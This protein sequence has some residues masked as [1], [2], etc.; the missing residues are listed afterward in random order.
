MIPFL[1]QARFPAPEFDN[2]TLPQLQLETLI[3]DPIAWRVSALLIFLV[4][5]GLCFYRWRSS[6]AMRLLALAG[7]VIFG[8]LFTACPCPVGMFQNLLAAFVHGQPLGYGLLLLFAIPLAAALLFG[9]LFCAGACPL[10]AVQEL[11]LWKPIQIPLHVDRALRLIP[12]A[13]F[14]LVVVAVVAG[15]AFPLCSLDPYLPLFLWS[16]SIPTVAFLVLGLFVSRPFC[17]YVCP[18]GVLLRLFS[19]VSWKTPSVTVQTCI[20]CRL[21]EQG[22]PNGAILPPESAPTPEAQA[23]GVRRLSRL[24]AAVPLALCLGGVLGWVAAPVISAAHPA[25]RLLADIE[26][27]RTS[28]EVEAF[29]ASG[30]PLAQL[31]NEVAQTRH[32]F[33]WGMPLAGVLLAGAVMAELIAQARRRRESSSYTI[34]QSLCYCCGRCYAACPLNRKREARKGAAT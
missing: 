26:A 15:M 18:Y 24:I 6:K 4:V 21:C 2:Y 5:S 8:F 34:D 23:R 13:L 31:Q 12:I 29:E 10:G 20:T 22:C 30:T 14:L 1:A 27:H 25:V 28:D 33:D 17:R 9:R 11:L 3:R 19:L 32:V 7:V 16:C